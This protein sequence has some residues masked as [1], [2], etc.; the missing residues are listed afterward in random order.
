MRD[1]GAELARPL[2]TDGLHL[3]RPPA[4]APTKVAEIMFPQTTRANPV[5]DRLAPRLAEM[6]IAGGSGAMHVPGITSLIQ[7]DIP[8]LDSEIPSVNAVVT[9]RGLAKMYGALAN[10]GCIDGT[11]FLSSEL[12][13]GLAGKLSLRP[14]FNILF[15]MSFHLGYHGSPVPGLL[16]GLAT[17]A[18]VEPSGGPIPSPRARSP[19]YTIGSS[20]PWS[21]TKSCLCH[22]F[23]PCGAPSPRPTRAAPTPCRRSVHPTLKPTRPAEPAAKASAPAARSLTCANSPTVITMNR[24]VARQ[25]RHQLAGQ[26]DP[27][28]PVYASW[29]EPGQPVLPFSARAPLP[30]GNGARRDRLRAGPVSSRPGRRRRARMARRALRTVAKEH[31][32]G[33]QMS[34]ERRRAPRNDQ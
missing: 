24:A 29:F 5:F 18:C 17:P 22:L 19:S 4:E 33:A 20:R 11:Q 21:S 7:G 12:A 25:E 23:C 15:P 30:G 6:P 16:R 13:R 26:H 34:G 9:A 31:N 2:N 28:D 27:A 1:S 8:F 10:D 14:D 3:G 32:L